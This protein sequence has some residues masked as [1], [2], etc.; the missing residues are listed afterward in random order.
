M[1]VGYCRTST[2]EQKAGYEAQ[3]RDLKSQGCEKVFSE[4]VSSVNSNRPEL[5]RAID[6][7]RENDVLVVTRLDRL[8]RSVADLGQIVAR[9]EAKQVGLKIL[10][11]SIDTTSPTGRLLMNL[12]GSIAQFEREIMLARQREG[13]AKAKAEH[14]FKGRAP[15]ARRKSSVVVSMH[16]A[17]KK[18]VDIANELGIGRSSVYRILAEAA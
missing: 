4:Q 10:D 1:F 2:I 6:F 9:L 13:I 11:M 17:G 7:V 16:Q 18:P 8:A 5:D 15:T 12:V 14:K 3:L